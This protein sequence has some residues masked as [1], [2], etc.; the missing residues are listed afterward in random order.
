MTCYQ[1]NLQF[2]Q[3]LEVVSERNIW[4]IFY[5]HEFW[6]FGFFARKTNL[7]NMSITN[8]YNNRSS[9][10]NKTLIFSYFL[11][12]GTIKKPTF[13]SVLIISWASFFLLK[14]ALHKFLLSICIFCSSVY[15]RL[16]FWSIGIKR[17]LTEIEQKLRNITQSSESS[18]NMK[19]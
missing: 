5:L 15:L 11:R 13:L 6:G 10:L 16:I 14:S 19:I 3:V 17:I 2:S 9:N 8:R 18:K 7:T 4:K 12:P 1:S